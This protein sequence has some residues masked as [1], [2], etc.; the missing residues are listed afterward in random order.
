MSFGTVKF[1]RI[2]KMKCIKCDTIC[3]GRQWH[4]QQEGKTL[5]AVCSVA[6]KKLLSEKE[7]LLKYGK[8]GVHYRPVGTS[9]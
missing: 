5:C 4:K 7:M 1:A 8:N 2:I 6:E 3:R 9:I